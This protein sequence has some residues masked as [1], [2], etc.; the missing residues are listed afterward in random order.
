[1]F[2]SQVDGGSQAINYFSLDILEMLLGWSQSTGVSPNPLDFNERG[3]AAAVFDSL[4]ANLNQVIG[5]QYTKISI[6][7][8]GFFILEE[9]FYLTQ[10]LGE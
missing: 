5:Y 3:I 2:G 1:M 9:V 8:C 10:G 7:T 6:Q 4:V